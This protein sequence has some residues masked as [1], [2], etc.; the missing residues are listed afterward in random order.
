MWVSPTVFQSTTN[1]TNA[2]TILAIA[3][4]NTP[5]V[6]PILKAY[7]GKDIP[8]EYAKKEEESKRAAIE[9]WERKN[10]NRSAGGGGGFLGGMFG[11]VSA[12]C[13]PPSVFFL[14]SPYPPS[15]PRCATR[16][17]DQPGQTRPNQ[18]MT[19]LDQKRA[20]AQKMYQEEQKYW[21]ENA[22]DFKKLVCVHTI[23]KRV[24]TTS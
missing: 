15:V 20:Q 18:P 13:P 24:K 5:D 1:Q 4:F 16:T 9:E 7:D 22:E 2:D 3:I 8:I 11:S 6:R 23:F 14:L 17:D 21:A 10:P 19:Y 12:V